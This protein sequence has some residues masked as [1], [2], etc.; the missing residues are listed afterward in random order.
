MRIDSSYALSRVPRLLTAALAGLALAGGA[1]VPVRAAAAAP[2]PP[3]D[4]VPTPVLDWRPCHDIAE[5]ATVRL[6]LDYDEPTGETVGVGVLRVRARDQAHRIGSLFVNPGGLGNPATALALSAPTLLS[7]P[8]L[9]RF[10]IVGVDPRGVGSSEHLD[11]FTSAADRAEVLDLLSVPFPVTRAET[12]DYLRGS[13]LLGQ[14]CSTTGRRLA[15]SV[16]TAETAQDMDVIRRAVGD[17]KLT[18]Y[19]RS[20]GSQLGQVYANMFPDRFRALAVDGTFDPTAWVGRTTRVIFDERAHF[21]NGTYRTLIE[22]LRR[23]DTAGER[24]CVFAAGDPVRNFDSIA[25]RLR[26]RSL[27]FDGG[28]MTYAEF[29]MATST[30]LFRPDA[31][32]RVTRIAAD[33]RT[34]LDDGPDPATAERL[35]AVVAA[36]RAVA[37]DNM[38]EAGKALQCT[39]G[40]YPAD[41]ASWPAAVAA[42]NRQAPYFGSVWGWF[43]SVCARGTWTVRDE[44]AYTGPFNRRTEAPVLIVGAIHD[45]GTNYRGAVAASLLLPHSTLLTSNNWGHTSYGRGPCVT[46]RIDAYLLSGEP[47]TGGATVCTDAPQPF[48]EPLP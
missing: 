22:V 23:C 40:L 16:S 12:D 9:D 7:G 6:P 19:G 35:R 2:A 38:T 29:V 24:Y 25:R 14:A 26:H 41:V 15:G 37:D 27:V 47:P 13:R 28:T 32:A 44:D 45:P 46:A 11:C 36:V 1:A 10:D 48:L 18:Y 21:S 39:D 43:D 30:S 33:V 42:R 17:E 8:L 3:V 4:A 34:A 5:C 20:Y 31:G